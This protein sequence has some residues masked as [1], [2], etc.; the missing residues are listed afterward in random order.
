[1][2]TRRAHGVPS[3]ERLNLSLLCSHKRRQS[4]NVTLKEVSSAYLT[5]RNAAHSDQAM[6]PREQQPVLLDSEVIGDRDR[7]P[8]ESS[9]TS[10]DRQAK[11][12]A[13]GSVSVRLYERIVGDHPGRFS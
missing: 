10:L 9:L 7:V 11:G 2:E 13:F 5:Q 12:V 3:N 8:S 4:V 1:M 6:S